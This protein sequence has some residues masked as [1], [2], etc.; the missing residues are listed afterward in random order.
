MPTP[1]V[2][3]SA[4]SGARPTFSLDAVYR[5]KWN[6]AFLWLL[7][8]LVVD[9]VDGSMARAAKVKER[10]PR[11]DGEALVRPTRRA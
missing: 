4:G 2:I 8:A 5:E 3:R 7:V 1:A 10:L 6:E 11:I 9:G